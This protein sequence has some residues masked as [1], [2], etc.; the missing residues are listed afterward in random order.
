[1]LYCKRDTTV[2]TR[3]KTE[4][5]YSEEQVR[6]YLLALKETKDS[7]DRIRN[8]CANVCLCGAQE[9]CNESIRDVQR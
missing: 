9:L 8:S 5:C 2:G 7:V 6:D 4:N 3:I 1:M